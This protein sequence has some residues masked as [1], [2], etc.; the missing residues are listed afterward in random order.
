MAS[1]LGRMNSL[2]DFRNLRGGQRGPPPT[3]RFLAEQAKN[4]ATSQQLQK[5]CGIAALATDDDSAADPVADPG[6]PVSAD[7]T[8][9]SFMASPPPAQRWTESRRASDAGAAMHLQP[10]PA[11]VRRTR[12]R[13]TDGGCVYDSATVLHTVIERYACCWPH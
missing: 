10:S 13:A 12:R 2:E 6:T 8:P 3:S 5:A 9:K 7:T 4:A 1:N 11:E